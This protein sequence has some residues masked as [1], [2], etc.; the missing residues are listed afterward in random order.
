M[1]ATVMKVLLLGLA[2]LLAGITTPWGA[3]AQTLDSAPEAEMTVEEMAGQLR[4]LVYPAPPTRGATVSPPPTSP[5]LRSI[6]FEFGSDKLTV[7]AEATLDN[8]AAAMNLSDIAHAAFIVEG[9]TDAVGSEAFNLAL[10]QR[11]ADATV[12]YLTGRDV[13]PARLDATGLGETQLLERT[14]GPSQQNR[15]VEVRFTETAS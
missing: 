10:S 9:H 5:V 1:I 2:L 4:A 14:D 3:T 11:R 15:R 13:D 7:E 12:M 6:N 8:L